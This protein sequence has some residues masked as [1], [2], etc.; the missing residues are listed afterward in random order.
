[1][2]VHCT[3]MC[4]FL[5][6]VM[7]LGQM[8]VLSRHFLIAL[9]LALPLAYILVVAPWKLHNIT[10]FQFWLRILKEII[11]VIRSHQEAQVPAY[12]FLWKNDHSLHTGVPWAKGTVYQEMFLL[13]RTQSW[14]NVNIRHM[15]YTYEI[16]TYIYT[17]IRFIYIKL[18]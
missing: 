9:A 1:M 17:Q 10:T 18:A 13:C 16:Y 7:G 2:P 14:V 15:I 4:M 11:M 8:L 12:D 6:Y 5:L 3:F